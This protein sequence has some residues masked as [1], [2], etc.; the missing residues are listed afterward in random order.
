MRSSQAGTTSPG[1]TQ[2]HSEA[3]STCTLRD[4]PSLPGRPI[5]APCI[6][7]CAMENKKGE[8][9]LRAQRLVIGGDRVTACLLCD[10]HGGPQASGLVIEALPALL[11]EY[12]NGDASGPGLCSA[13]ERA[14]RLLHA[15]LNHASAAT[16]AGTTVT[17]CLINET[18]GELTCCSVGDSFAVLVTASPDESGDLRKQDKQAPLITELTVNPR[19]DDCASERQRVRSEGGQIGRAMGSDGTP[20]GPLRA[21]PGGVSCA[22][23]L[24][25]SDC[26]KFISPTPFTITLPFPESGGAVILASDGVWDAVNFTSAAKLALNASTATAAAEAVVSKSMRARGLRD[27]ITCLVAVSAALPPPPS[28]ISDTSSLSPSASPP[29]MRGGGKLSALRSLMRRPGASRKE[30]PADASVKGGN[31]FAGFAKDLLGSS[32]HSSGSGGSSG[33]SP[34]FGRS[35]DSTQSN[36]GTDSMLWPSIRRGMS[37]RSMDASTH[38]SNHSHRSVDGIDNV[39]LESP[40]STLDGSIPLFAYFQGESPLLYSPS[41]SPA[42]SR[43]GSKTNLADLLSEELNLNLMMPGEPASASERTTVN[44][45]L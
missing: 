22:S 33:G 21:W 32:S 30:V 15:K 10:G 2:N 28:T 35:R 16:T 36:S 20:V 26:G 19:L 9:G 37:G 38:V 1:M 23:A 24:G 11:A 3:D 39:A 8:D 14:F 12:S 43:S 40:D 18:R 34:S 45:P 7:G 42:G 44:V 6:L 29:P 31:L 5:L 41:A 4:G 17:L 27:D 13:A 25:D